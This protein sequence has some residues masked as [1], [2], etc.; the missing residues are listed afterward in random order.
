MEKTIILGA[1]CFWGVEENFS[2]LEGV[3]QTQV[4]YAGG[5]TDNP[6]YKEVC[7]KKTG[8]AEVVKVV[9]DEKKISLVE[10]LEFF[11]KIHDPSQVNGQ[12]V[13]IGSQ[14]RSTIFT[15]NE[16][17]KEVAEKLRDE[18]QEKI[19]KKDKITTE[20]A[21]L[22]NY[23]KAEEYHQKYIQKKKKNFF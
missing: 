17:D 3:L 13:D 9:F 18:L 19:Y 4:G 20:I 12:G 16:Q 1:G 2:Q 8:H 14:Y 15:Q 22:P 7:S 21:I 5:Y 10:I 23:Y 6:T 11:F